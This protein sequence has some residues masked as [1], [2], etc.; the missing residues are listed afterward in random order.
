MVKSEF[1]RS[2]YPAS[3]LLKLDITGLLRVADNAK[4]Y[5]GIQPEDTRRRHVAA[6]CLGRGAICTSNER[7]G[8]RYCYSSGLVTPAPTCRHASHSP[9][10][11]SS[12]RREGWSCHCIQRPA[13]TSLH[14]A[15]AECP[16]PIWCP[17]APCH[18]VVYPAPKSVLFLHAHI[19]PA[20]QQSMDN[21]QYILYITRLHSWITL[22]YYKLCCPSIHII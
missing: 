7:E 11:S 17:L 9:S 22:F 10:A 20:S 5:G 2:R 21:K 1:L 18:G 6:L 13:P 15:F 16:P 4:Q 8:F 19:P 3:D 12:N 14:L